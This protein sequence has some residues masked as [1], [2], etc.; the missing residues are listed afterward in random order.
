MGRLHAGHNACTLE[1]CH[2]LIG[3]GF[4]VLDPV[5]GSAQDV[6]R[7]SVSQRFQGLQHMGNPGI[8]D[9]VRGSGDTA[10]G[11]VPDGGGVFF[12]PR[13][14]RCGGLAMN[15]RFV[16]PGCSVVHGAID[17]EFDGLNGPAP[18]SCADAARQFF[19][20]GFATA[21]HA[22]RRG[23]KPQREF[24]VRLQCLEECGGFL[25]VVHD[26]AARQA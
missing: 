22:P 8:A 6:S 25:A 18:A 15:I 21:R 7:N 13:P 12:G 2:Q 24:A 23:P 20:F 16:E 4:D 1:S 11:K 14:E 5:D 17:E 9:S 10:G 19:P 3:H 26:V